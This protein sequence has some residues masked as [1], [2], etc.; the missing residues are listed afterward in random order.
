[1]DSALTLRTAD[2]AA[3]IDT[4]ADLDHAMPAEVRV[5]DLLSAV[6]SIVPCDLIFWNRFDVSTT[7]GIVA[8]AGYPHRTT[9]AS[10]TEWM[11]HRHEH[12]ICSGLHG[13]VVSHSDIL[14]R[15]ELHDSWLYQ[16]CLSRSGWEHEIGVNL[17]HP[18]GEIQFIVISRTPGRDF[19]QRDHQVLRLLLPHLDTA[20]RRIA[21]P[22]PSLT[23]RQI[24]ILRHVRDGLGNRP[25]AR[26]L[27]LSEAT[28]VKHLEN[29]YDRLG[30]HSRTQAL[31]LCAGL[32]EPG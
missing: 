29:A 7:P 23:P 13:S 25:I 1:M 2:L 5:A 20:L 11:A 10:T 14:S 24:E 9:R 3:I 21:Y 31:Q 4:S 26:R 12:P 22:A 17:S 19:D 28:V 27:G 18:A 6:A 16:E 15:D 32:L 30:A 8:E